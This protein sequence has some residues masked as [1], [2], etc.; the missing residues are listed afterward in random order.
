[1]TNN[2]EGT[3]EFDFAGKNRKFKLD[4]KTLLNIENTLNKPI[5][6]VAQE[7]IAGDIGMF[8]VTTIL[9]GGLTCAGGKFTLEAVGNMVQQ[10]GLVNSVSI[11]SDL[12]TRAMGLEVQEDPKEPTENEVE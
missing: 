3:L 10:H 7:I 6:K 4:F 5:M 9:H 1:M 8:N 11:V 2:I 12:L